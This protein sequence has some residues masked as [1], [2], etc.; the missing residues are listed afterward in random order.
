MSSYML[1]EREV[2][3]K[4]FSVKSPPKRMRWRPPRELIPLKGPLG[5]H[6]PLTRSRLPAQ[7]RLD[8]DRLV[9]TPPSREAER[10][11]AVS[12][13]LLLAFLKIRDA[14]GVLRFAQRYGVLAI[15]EH[16]WPASHRPIPYPHPYALQRG[17]EGILYYLP[18]NNVTGFTQEYEPV[19]WCVPLGSDGG[20]PWEPVA[21]WLHFVGQASTILNL[22]AVL[23]GS[24]PRRA[25][26]AA[27]EGL[28]DVRVA[29]RCAGQPVEEQRRLLAACVEEWLALG[30]PILRLSWSERMPQISIAAGTFGL[31]A[32]QLAA[33]VMGRSR[34]AWCSECGNPYSPERKPQTGRRNYCPDCREAG[35]PERIRAREYWRKKRR[36]EQQLIPK[37]GRT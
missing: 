17:A 26:Q 13:G 29:Q 14:D 7:V 15:C 3:I 5:S 6:L 12:E 33:A 34:M 9:W 20:Q 19:S 10:E 22:A 31:L 36:R 8:G 2:S 24:R 1:S 16:G 4:A 30:R 28:F 11:P 37:G 21:R 18:E 23:N 32:S 35:E 27:W 25:G